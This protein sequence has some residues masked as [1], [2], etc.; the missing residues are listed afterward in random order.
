MDEKEIVYIFVS[1]THA[2]LPKVRRVRDYLE[3]LGTEPILFYLKSLTDKDKITRLIEDEIDARIW[4]VYCRSELAE[5]SNWVRTELEYV[6][7]TGKDNQL[8]IDLETAFDKKGELTQEVKLT[9][10]RMLY[11]IRGVRNVFCSFAHR[12]A[13][14]VERVVSYLQQYDVA[15]YYEK[16]TFDTGCFAGHVD[17]VLRESQ[18]F[19]LFDSDAAEDSSFVEREKRRAEQLG[20]TFIVV[21]L[22]DGDA[23][24]FGREDFIFD[25]RDFDRSCLRLVYYLFDRLS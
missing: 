20:K 21:R 8:T 7:N 22:S 11:K 9:C 17:Q 15:L 24:V 5:E 2:D 19:L 4:F 25:C 18:F 3:S 23:R 14:V 16:P 13:P 1:H 10:R 12:D 6:A